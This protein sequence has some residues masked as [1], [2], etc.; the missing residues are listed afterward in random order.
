VA[1]GGRPGG[2]GH[3]PQDEAATAPPPQTQ[4]GAIMF[5]FGGSADQLYMECVIDERRAMG[6]ERRA[7]FRREVEQLADAERM[8]AGG[9]PEAR[10]WVAG[11]A[12]SARA[13]AW[14]VIHRAPSDTP[15]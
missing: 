4:G 5:G 12:R 11:V 9:R 3:C 8:A 10:G 2:G 7:G 13:L 6:D 1:G 14:V 15:A